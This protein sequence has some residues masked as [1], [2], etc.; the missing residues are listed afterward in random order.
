MRKEINEGIVDDLKR[1]VASHGGL[2][3]FKSIHRFSKSFEAADYFDCP[4]TMQKYANH[5]SQ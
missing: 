5:F 1:E 4:S 3:R 2:S